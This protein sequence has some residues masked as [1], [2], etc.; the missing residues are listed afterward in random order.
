[1]GLHDGR[2]KIALAAPPVDGQA[3][4]ALVAFIASELKTSRS[5]VRLVSGQT[6][7]RKGAV[8]TGLTP[9]EVVAHLCV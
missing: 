3:N 7:R 2:L 5:T 9:A 1:M 8:I 6:G 4:K